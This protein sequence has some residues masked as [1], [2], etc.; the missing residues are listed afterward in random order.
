MV[1]LVCDLLLI[2]VGGLVFI[3]MLLGEMFMFMVEGDGYFLVEWCCVLDWVICLVLCI[4]VGVV[5]VNVFG[6][7]VCSYEVILDLV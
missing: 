6:G 5:D 1:G 4:V 3:I 2:V 7:E